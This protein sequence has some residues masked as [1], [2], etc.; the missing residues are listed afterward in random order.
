V[1]RLIQADKD[2]HSGGKAITALDDSSLPTDLKDMARASLMRIDAEGNVQLYIQAA[3]EI[4]GAIAEIN[5]LG[6]RVERFDADQGLIQAQVPIPKV[7]TLSSLA[8]VRYIRLP[9]YGFPQGGSTT[10]QGDSILKANLVRGQF[11]VDGTGVKVGVISDGLG[12]LASSQATGDLPAVNTSCNGVAGSDAEGTAMLE[13]VHDMAPGAELWFATGTGTSLEFNAAVDCLAA[14]TDVVVDDIGWFN[15][16]PYDGTSAVSAN[17]ST[18]LNRSSNRIRAY[19]TAVGNMADKHYQESFRSCSGSSF[20][21]FSATALTLDLG[22]FGPR[23]SNPLWVAPGGIAK[24]ALQWNDPWGGSCNDYDMLLTI[25]D[26]ATILASSTNPQTCWQN[27][28]ESVVWQNPLLVPVVVDLY[29]NNVSGLAAPRTFDLFTSPD[30]LPYF[31]TR[32]SSVPNQSDAGGGVISVGA[33]A[34][35]DPGND[36]IENYSSLGPTNDGRTKPDITGIDCVNITGAGGFQTPFCGTSAAA[37]H[38]AGIAALL[39][40]CNPGLRAGE[41]GDNP[42]SDR[43]ALRG[44][45]LDHAVDL[46]AT[47]ADYVYGAGRADALAS[48]NSICSASTP[49]PTAGTFHPLTPARI[50]DTRTSTGGH[51]FKVGEG[52]EASIQVTGVGGVPSSGVSAVALNV[53]VTEPTLSSHLTVYPSDASRPNTSNLNFVPGQTVPNMVI[54]KVGPDGKVKVYNYRGQTHVIFDVTGWFGTGSGNASYNPLTPARILDTR[55]STGGHPFK[56]GEGEEASIQVTGVGGVPSSGVSAVAL[57]VT[58]TEPTLSSHLTVYPSDASRPNTSNLNFVP[59]QTVPNMVIA[60]VGP[61]GK[62]KVYNYRGQTHVIF[63]VTG[64]FG[65]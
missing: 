42:G 31:V 53:T 15:V 37:P 52:E 21:L 45:L 1:A 27:P 13:I 62:V 12:G 29:I 64:W 14:N 51:P 6:G 48:A 24:V 18:E 58:V 63:D 4:E 39:L 32:W 2:A 38:I 59:G 47:G 26:S 43:A 49:P 56:V 60:K 17:T 28:S 8:S 40:Q 30:A 5:A 55:T 36:T 34:A 10:T 11:G 23:C 16:G 22:G 41:P 20:H 61:D 57:N 44:A 46:G 35:S 25:H 50:L 54:A 7:E 3:G 65:P 19:V 33:I 9:D